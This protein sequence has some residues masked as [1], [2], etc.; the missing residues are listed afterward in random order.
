MG[1]F[2]RV[3]VIVLNWNGVE[4]GGMTENLNT[5]SSLVSYEK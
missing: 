5:N 3:S 1:S 4:D 2:A